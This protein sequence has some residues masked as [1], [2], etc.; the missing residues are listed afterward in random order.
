MSL[1]W[2]WPPF[3]LC[4]L[5]SLWTFSK[6]STKQKVSEQISVMLKLL[7]A[8][9]SLLFCTCQKREAGWEAGQEWCSPGLGSLQLGHLHCFSSHYN[10]YLWLQH[11]VSLTAQSVSSLPCFCQ[12]PC[13]PLDYETNTW[14]HYIDPNMLSVYLCPWKLFIQTSNRWRLCCEAVTAARSPLIGMAFDSENASVLNDVG[15]TSFHHLTNSLWS[16]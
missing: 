6:L 10:G 1:T 14:L 16:L 11:L 9:S 13:S 12:S 3:N 4:H 15:D 5:F 2:K 8:F 7:P